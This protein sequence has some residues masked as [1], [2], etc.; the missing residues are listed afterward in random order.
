[1]I[2]DRTPLTLSEV[3]TIL[4]DIPESEKKTQ[5]EEYLKKFLKAKHASAAKTIKEE[6][7]ALDIL[8]MKSEHIVKIVDLMPEDISDINKIFVDISLSEEEANKILN[9]VKNN[10]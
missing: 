10:K 7:E 4:K 8:K 3:D 1:M 6:L 2:I 9:V 5:A